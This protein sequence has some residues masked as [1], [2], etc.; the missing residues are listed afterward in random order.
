MVF[1]NIALLLMIFLTNRRTR[2][3][4]SIVLYEIRFKTKNICKSINSIA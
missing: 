2:L 1:V 3:Q 4:H